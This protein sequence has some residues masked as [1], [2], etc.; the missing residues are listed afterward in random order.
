MKRPQKDDIVRSE[1][2]WST[3]RIETIDPEDATSIEEQ[4]EPT[5]RFEGIIA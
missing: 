1:T 4:G 3:E 5:V 2:T